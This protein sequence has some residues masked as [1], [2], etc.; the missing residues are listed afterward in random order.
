MKTDKDE[1]LSAAAGGKDAYQLHFAHSGQL[2]GKLSYTF[3]AENNKPGDALYLYYYYSQPGVCEGVQLAVV[4]SNGY[5]TFDIYHCSSYFVS[6]ETIEGAAGIN[7]A[8]GT[9]ESLALREAEESLAEAEESR[10]QL[11]AQ[12]EDAQNSLE[13]LQAEIDTH[14]SDAAPEENPLTAQV[15]GP[16]ENLFGVPYGSLIAALLG[17]ALAAMFLTMLI[18]RVGI[19]KKNERTDI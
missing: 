3:K 15:F 19:F 7:F 9:E 8:A 2:P 12:L 5:V 1:S 11:Q 10:A 6:A 14:R 16:V 17:A 4:D 13:K 18:C